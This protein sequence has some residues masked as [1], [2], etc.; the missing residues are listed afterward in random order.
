MLRPPS[1]DPESSKREYINNFEM[2]VDIFNVFNRTNLGS[3]VGVLSSPYFGR[4]NA[5]SR[6]RTLQVSARYRF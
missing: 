5:A 4:A 6:P 2:N 3:Y 1:A